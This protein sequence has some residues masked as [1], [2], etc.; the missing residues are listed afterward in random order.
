MENY[1]NIINIKME[2]QMAISNIFFKMVILNKKEFLKM[3]MELFTSTTKKEKIQMKQNIEKEF[4]SKE[5]MLLTKQMD[6]LKEKILLIKK[7]ET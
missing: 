2:F 4:N 6:Q 1:G 5:Y 7:K 3:G